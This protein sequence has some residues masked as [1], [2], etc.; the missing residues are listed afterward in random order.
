VQGRP[1][2]EFAFATSE[3]WQ[4]GSLRLRPARSIPWLAAAAFGG[5]PSPGAGPG[6]N[7]TRLQG[8]ETSAPAIG[9]L[10]IAARNQRERLFGAIVAIC[11]E[12]GYEATTIK[13][14]VALSGVSRRD[15]CGHFAD[16]EACFLAAMDAILALGR[17]V[18]RRRHDGSGGE[19][20]VLI[21]IAAEQPAATRFGLLESC[22]AGS[23]AAA[24]PR[25]PTWKVW[26]RWAR[27]AACLARYPR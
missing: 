1:G 20:E 13:G 22:A 3:R 14:V 17:E 24:A 4:T 11:A 18:A 27:T 16:K 26:G 25:P 2:R 5:R 9:M 7:R 12:R 23:A 15:F 10:Q 19:F 8:F 6:S 21:R